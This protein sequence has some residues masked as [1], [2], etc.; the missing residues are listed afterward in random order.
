MWKCATIV[1]MGAWDLSIEKFKFWMKDILDVEQEKWQEVYEI[2]WEM[3]LLHQKYEKE[4]ATID[5]RDIELIKE[6]ENAET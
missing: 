5:F 4:G 1:G 6:D 3:L 2:F